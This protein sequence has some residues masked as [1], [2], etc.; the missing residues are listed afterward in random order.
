MPLQGFLSVAKK[1]GRPIREKKGVGVKKN[2]WGGDK[3]IGGGVKIVPPLDK[4]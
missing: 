4:K 2:R 3:K 1:W